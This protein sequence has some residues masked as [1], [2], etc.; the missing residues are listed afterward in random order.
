[1]GRRAK[2]DFQSPE[3]DILNLFDETPNI[4]VFLRVEQAARPEP[5]RLLPLFPI[6]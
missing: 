2:P 4:T 5:P 6:R 1:M 3:I